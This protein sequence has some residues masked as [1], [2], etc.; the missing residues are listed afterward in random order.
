MIYHKKDIILGLK[1]EKR[2]KEFLDD[3]WKIELEYTDEFHPFDLYYKKQNLYIEVKTRRCK[4]NK[5][6]TLYFS[7]AKL[8]YINQNPSNNYMFVYNLNDGLYLWKFNINQL[9]LSMGGRTDRGKNEVKYL[10]N[11]P[12]KYLIKIN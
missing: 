12:V 10:C 2:V 1:G 11:I 3:E 6:K 9:F 5:Y 8:D 4:H 7:K